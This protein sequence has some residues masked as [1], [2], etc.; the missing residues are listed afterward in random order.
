MTLH[1][2][3]DASYCPRTK[4]GIIII[5]IYQDETCII[6]E[7][8]RIDNINNTQLED[9]G[10]QLSLNKVKDIASDKVIIYSDSESCIKKYN[11]NNNDERINFIYIKGHDRKINRDEIGLKF[12]EID[13]LARKELKRVRKE[14][15]D[16]SNN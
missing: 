3:S 7:I 13:I 5:K 14:L 15:D 6:N 8:Q 2:F 12:R 9:M 1:C 4:I 10:I 16:N 11:K